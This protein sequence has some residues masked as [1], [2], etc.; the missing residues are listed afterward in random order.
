[1]LGGISSFALLLRQ[2]PD[3]DAFFQEP[4]ADGAFYK[5]R[6]LTDHIDGDDSKACK[7]G[8]AKG[9]WY[10]QHPN[11]AAVKQE[12]NEGLTAG[13]KGEIGCMGI[14]VE[15]HHKRCDED[16]LGGQ[17]PHIISGVVQAGADPGYGCPTATE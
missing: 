4:C 14:G 1:M 17:L 15:Y 5:I 10:T 7:P 11:E 13:T 16:E 12:G 6:A 2:I 8:Q 9:Q 3:P